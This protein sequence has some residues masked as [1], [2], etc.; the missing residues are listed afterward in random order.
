MRVR[1][2]ELL[3]G[4]HT[5]RLLG[6]NTPVARFEVQDGF[7]EVLAGTVHPYSDLRFLSWPAEL[8]EKVL[9]AL[10]AGVEEAEWADPAARTLDLSGRFAFGMQSDSRPWRVRGFTHLQTCDLKIIKHVLGV[11]S[12]EPEAS[13]AWWARTLGRHIEPR[14]FLSALEA[15]DCREWMQ[16]ERD[17]DPS[18]NPPI[19]LYQALSLP[20]QAECLRILAPLR[21]GFQRA[22]LEAIRGTAA[23]PG[24]RHAHSQE[25]GEEMMHFLDDR[26]LLVVARGPADGLSIVS[27]YDAHSEG[28]GELGERTLSRWFHQ[29]H[30]GQRATRKAS[31]PVLFH[32]P[33]NWRSLARTHGNSSP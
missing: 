5:L 17:R 8:R 29:L 14:E 18:A 12:R 16:L 30:T 32:T 26:G 2:V 6:R 1:F 20:A 22:V 31:S 19:R 33:E 28:E 9:L 4:Q 3:A 15:V 24:T 23:G 10:C 25:A 21:E 27:A 7:A 13:V 11:G